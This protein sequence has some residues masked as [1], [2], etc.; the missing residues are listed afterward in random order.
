MKVMAST[1]ATALFIPT[2]DGL[3]SEKQ[4]AMR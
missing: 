1:G 3:P 2:N 4:M